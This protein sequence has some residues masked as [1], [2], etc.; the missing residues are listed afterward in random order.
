M[1]SAAAARVALFAWAIE[2]CDV[3]RRGLE[4]LRW[5]LQN[6]VWANDVGRQRLGSGGGMRGGRSCTECRAQADAEYLVK[7]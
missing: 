6:L 3:V 2:A 7:R 5:L 1:T 4:I